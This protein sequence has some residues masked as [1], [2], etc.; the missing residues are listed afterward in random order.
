MK[1]SGKILDRT[2]TPNFFAIPSPPGERGVGTIKSKQKQKSSAMGVHGDVNMGPAREFSRRGTRGNS[3]GPKWRDQGQC[4]AEPKCPYGWGYQNRRRY[5]FNRFIRM[6][7]LHKTRT[8]FVQGPAAL[9]KKRY[10]RKSNSRNNQNFVEDCSSI[11]LPSS[12][13]PVGPP[14]LTSLVVGT[15]YY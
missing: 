11:L 12:V 9:S 5:S 4:Q 14:V 7:V 2:K 15:G 1:S 8:D 13:L 3:A 10:V 6:S